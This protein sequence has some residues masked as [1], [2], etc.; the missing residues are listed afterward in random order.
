MVIIIGATLQSRTSFRPENAKRFSHGQGFGISHQRIK[1]VLNLNESLMPLHPIPFCSKS[2][3]LE[4][5]IAYRSEHEQADGV[6]A[7]SSP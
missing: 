1:I 3:C 4:K 2:F 5:G 6:G 7:G